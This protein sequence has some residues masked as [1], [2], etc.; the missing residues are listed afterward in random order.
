MQ[1]S[2]AHKIQKEQAKYTV[3][4]DGINSA[5]VL[6]KKVV[7]GSTEGTKGSLYQPSAHLG[8]RMHKTIYTYADNC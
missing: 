4:P 8:N 7:D 1:K 6:V 3:P 5:P 2:Y